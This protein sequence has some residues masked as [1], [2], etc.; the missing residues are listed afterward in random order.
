MDMEVRDFNY[1]F[2]NGTADYAQVT[3][4][5][6]VNGDGEYINSNIRVDK[7]D[8]AGGNL[9]QAS[10]QDV[11]TIARKKLAEYTAVKQD[12]TTTKPENADN[13]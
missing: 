8:V 9:L 10:M 6:D 1:H 3:L 2:E 11:I 5:S 13:Q 4:Y 12:S 7:A